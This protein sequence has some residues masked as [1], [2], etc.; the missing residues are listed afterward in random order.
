MPASPAELIVA[1]HPEAAPTAQTLLHERIFAG[2]LEG[3]S[4]KPLFPRAALA[5]ERVLRAGGTPDLRA[6]LA[7]KTRYFSVAVADR[8]RESALEE[9][10]SLP[11]V[12]TAY[13]KPGV[14]NPL[15]PLAPTDAPPVELPA[16]HPSDFRGLQTYVGAAPGGVGVASA[17]PRPGGRGQ[18]VRVID[19]EGGWKFTHT[20]L[21]VNSGGLLAGAMYDDVAWRNHGTAVLGELGGDEDDFGICGICPSAIL[22]GVSHGEL[23]SSRAIEIAASLLS[24]G[25][26]LLL[27]M[28]RPGPRHAYEVR[29]D[30]KGYIA[31]EWWP[32]DLAAIQGA[33]ARGIVVVEAAGNG[34]ENLDDPIYNVAGPR[35]PAG[36]RN[37]FSGAVDSG[38]VLVGAGAPPSGFFGPDRSRLDF[39]NW[40][41]RVDCQG[42][43][44]GVVSTGYGDFYRDAQDG[45]D[46]NYWYTR[47]FSGTSSASPIVTGVVA[48]LL[49]IAKALGRQLTPAE[50]REALR[51]T[52]SPQEESM[53]APVSQRIGRRPDLG[54]LLSYLSL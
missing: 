7:E 50:I 40:G 30:Q 2:R 3:L 12:E 19:I 43:G 49:G 11:G 48:C 10:N 15:A 29:N 32:D 36:W 33:V 41:A 35:F 27:E 46:E 54:A 24:P 18:G 13:W 6:N 51:A 14:E 53:T 22:S 26:V 47:E 45:H 5:T 25:D 31:V 17:W 28:H 42:W 37:P 4:V 52:G 16:V 23:G 38:A 1:F 20:D 8:T 44:R 21:L 9:M 39:S 34:A